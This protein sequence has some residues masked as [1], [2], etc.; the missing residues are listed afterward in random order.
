VT[1]TDIEA[2]NGVV[3]LIDTVIMPK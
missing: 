3:H 2:S 1:A